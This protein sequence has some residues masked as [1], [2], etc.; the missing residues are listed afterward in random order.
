VAGPSFSFHSTDAHETNDG[1]H[2]SKELKVVIDAWAYGDPIPEEYAFCVPD[3]R[4]HCAMGRNLSPAIRWSDAPGGTKSFAVICHDSDVPSRPDNVNKDGQ[5]V[6]ADLPRID[7]YHWVLVD[8]PAE[9]R[10]LPKGADSDGIKPGGKVPGR[11]EF[12]VRGINNYTDWFAS[13]EQMK[14]DYGGY[15]GPCPPWNDELVHHYHFTVYALDVPSLRLDGRFGGP[16]ALAA[17]QRH[18]LAKGG[19]MGTYTLNNPKLRGR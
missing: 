14:G 8:I 2:M 10:E 3:E 19:W 4:A 9:C 16:E 5:V 15:D 1:G 6:A 17:L 12:G 18:I 7:F 13:D 11:T